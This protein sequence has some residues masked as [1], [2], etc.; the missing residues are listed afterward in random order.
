MLGGWKKNRKL[1]SVH[2][3]VF[4]TGEYEWMWKSTLEYLTP[5]KTQRLLDYQL[6]GQIASS[7]I[8][9]IL[10]QILEKKFVNHPTC[11]THVLWPLSSLLIT[12]EI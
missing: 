2:A 8:K 3:L 4:R 11:S 6:G 5:K 12:L 1:T 9:L 7:I 10:I